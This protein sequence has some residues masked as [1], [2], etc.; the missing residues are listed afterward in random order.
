MV[1]YTA[2]AAEAT[3]TT[4]RV[5]SSQQAANTITFFLLSLQNVNYIQAN[6]FLLF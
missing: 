4:S 1:V 5:T 6:V 2:A 3:K